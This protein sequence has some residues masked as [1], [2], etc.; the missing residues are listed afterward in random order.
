[1]YLSYVSLTVNSEGK[2]Y[3]L[4]TFVTF[5][6]VKWSSQYLLNCS[7]NMLLYQTCHFPTP[8]HFEGVQLKPWPLSEA[9]VRLCPVSD[10][11][12]SSVLPIILLDKISH[13]EETG[14]ERLHDLPWI[15]LLGSDKAPLHV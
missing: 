7:Q 11:S 15:T 14:S 2:D 3:I 4:V 12:G 6:V 10:C 9:L 13:I 5:E 8:H 1:M